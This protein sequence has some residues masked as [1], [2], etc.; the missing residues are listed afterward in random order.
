M[1]HREVTERPKEVDFLRVILVETKASAD[2]ALRRT[3]QRDL[4]AGEIET[5]EKIEAEESP[6]IKQNSSKRIGDDIL[7]YNI[8][9]DSYHRS[10]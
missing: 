2:K 6:K 4:K 9:F 10:I 7:K 3:D 1:I 8:D 5:K